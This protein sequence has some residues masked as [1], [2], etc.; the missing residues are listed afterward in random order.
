[1]NFTKPIVMKR[2]SH[3]GSSYYRMYSQKL[4]RI[5]EFFSELE[6]YNF[7]TLEMNYEVL[8]FCEQPYE[9]SIIMDNQVKKAVFDMWV[10]YTNGTEEFQEVKYSKELLGPDSA[11]LRS[12]E[13]IRREKR[14]CADNGINFS[15]R[16]EKEICTGRFTM[17]NLSIMAARNRRYI[18]R[19]SNYYNAIILD[20]LKEHK[21][22]T[23]GR[24][25][26]NEALPINYE[27]EHLCYMFYQGFI[28]MNIQD[29]PFDLKTEVSL[30]QQKEIF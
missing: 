27:L 17:K 2:A 3:Y 11:S 10:K 4:N 18:P 13:Q 30:C 6:Y 15:L 1:M 20:L 5:V 8:T 25:I 12:Q 14:W 7:L 24:L 19:D 22:I 28:T 21:C 23:V 29:R 26:E 9:I 16:T